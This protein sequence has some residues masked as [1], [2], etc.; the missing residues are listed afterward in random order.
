MRGGKAS[1]VMRDGSDNRSGSGFHPYSFRRVAAGS[2]KA[3]TLTAGWICLADEAAMSRDYA[4]VAH[5]W[6][7]P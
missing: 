7:A 4:H 6:A 5:L 2:P 1:A 3:R